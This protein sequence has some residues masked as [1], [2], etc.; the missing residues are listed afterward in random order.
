MVGKLICFLMCVGG[1]DCRVRK[2]KDENIDFCIIKY[3]L[4]ERKL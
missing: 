1:G 4:V 3:R 2:G